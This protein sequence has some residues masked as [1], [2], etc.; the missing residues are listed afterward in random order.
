M[1]E[2]HAPGVA[3]EVVEV[4]RAQAGLGGEVGND[5][6]DAD[7]ALLLEL[8]LCSREDLVRSEVLELEGTLR[9]LVDVW[10]QCSG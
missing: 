4:D 2:Q 9:R 3:D 8:I 10:Q 1:R 7:V 6:A 5:V